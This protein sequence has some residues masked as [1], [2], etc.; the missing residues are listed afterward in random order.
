MASG[1]TMA[2]PAPSLRELSSE[3]E[4]E[5]VSSDGSTR[6][7]VT[8]K[9]LLALKIFTGYVHRGTLPQSALRAASSL[10]EGAGKLRELVPFNR[11]LAKIR[12][13]GRFSSPLRKLRNR[14]LLPFN[15]VHSLSFAALDS[16]LR[17]GAG[18]RSHSTGYSLKSGGGG[19]FSSPL[20]R[21]GSIHC[22]ARETKCQTYNHGGYRI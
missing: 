3:C 22:T 2:F 6:P 11:V 4:T 13:Y 10:R 7:M 21:A 18:K 17:E 5:G 16:S 9:P 19:R 8:R 1:Q 20:R 14:F 12:G 15:E